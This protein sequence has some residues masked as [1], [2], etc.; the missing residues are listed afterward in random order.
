LIAWKEKNEKERSASVPVNLL[1]SEFYDGGQLFKS[2]VTK[3][4]GLF[5]QILNLPPT[6]RGKLGVG[7]FVQAI[8]AGTHTKA[9]EFLM[10]DLFCEELKL[11]YYGYE[12][13]LDDVVYY[14]Q[15]RL[16][17]HTLDTKAAEPMLGLQSTSN[18]SN[19]CPLCRG[20]TGTHDGKK[21]CYIGH[22]QLLPR[23]SYL[24][25]LGQSGYC[26]PVRYYKPSTPA[27]RNVANEVFID[28]ATSFHI[29]DMNDLIK[30]EKRL[31]ANEKR[32]GV[33]QRKRQRLDK[34]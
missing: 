28:S 11:L 23:H 9:E 10:I 13:T 6:Y 2:I 8:Y 27:L 19:G 31:E 30:F 4:W 15:V 16:V 20:V 12:L 21:N 34:R 5:I 29:N 17:L 32:V 18:S 7:M 14:V 24:R 22:R 33:E 25:Y 1:L 26:C 3:F